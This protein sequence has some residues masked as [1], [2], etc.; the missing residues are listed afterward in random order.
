MESYSDDEMM[1]SSPVQRMSLVRDAEEGEEACL[2]CMERFACATATP[3]MHAQFCYPCIFT[4]KREGGACPVC[5]VPVTQIEFKESCTLG[6]I[7]DI[8]SKEDWSF[9][10]DECLDTLEE[11]AEYFDMTPQEMLGHLFFNWTHYKARN[12]MERYETPG[13]NDRDPWGGID[14]EFEDA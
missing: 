3:C 2:I 8:M 6:E 14:L 1:I 9:A 10:D 4:I 13:D 5:R 7:S 12:D 11:F